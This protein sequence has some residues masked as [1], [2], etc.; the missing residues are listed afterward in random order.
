MIGRGGDKATK[1]TQQVVSSYK[2]RA[3]AFDE[4]FM[5]ATLY[6]KRI[7]FYFLKRELVGFNI[8]KVVIVLPPLE[9][10]STEYLKHGSQILP[11][12][13]PLASHLQ[14]LAIGTGIHQEEESRWLV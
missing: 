5:I 11:G 3:V 12:L 7:T 13:Q 6:R 1:R 9:Y 14:L 2:N 8:R 10:I 4:P